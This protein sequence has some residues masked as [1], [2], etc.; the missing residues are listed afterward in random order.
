M[1]DSREQQTEIDEA[2]K[3]QV[4]AELQMLLAEPSTASA[5]IEP[6]QLQS[7][8]ATN[9]AELTAAEGWQIHFVPHQTL[10]YSGNDPLRILREL[11]E[12]GAQYQ[13]EMHHQALPELAEL[14]PELCYLNW[15][16]RLTGMYPKMRFVNCLNGLRM[17]AT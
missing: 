3:E 13:I 11:R 7:T 9:T 10:F 16:I 5:E 12:L 6:Q 2:L 14:D 17:S 8:M 1:L 4:S 15:T